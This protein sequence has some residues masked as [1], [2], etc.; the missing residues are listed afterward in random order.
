[1]LPMLPCRM[2][3]HDTLFIDRDGKAFRHVL[4]YLRDGPE[5]V[6]PADLE[7][8]CRLLREAQYY[9]I[10]GL[11][12]LLQQH[13]QQLLSVM[14]RQEEDR[15]QQEEDRRQL[16]ED[17]RQQEEA[18]KEAVQQTKTLCDKM[19]SVE[20]L[21]GEVRTYLYP[22]MLQDMRGGPYY[23]EPSQLVHDLAAAIAKSVA[24]A[25]E[26]IILV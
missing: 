26:D 7:G 14:R 15:M 24:D 25:L 5:V 19:A 23:G 11:V 12:A 22:E 4:A 6:L 3:D 18:R 16:Q 9:Q 20:V 10:G 2:L 21:L 8:T 13:K 17:R 1:M